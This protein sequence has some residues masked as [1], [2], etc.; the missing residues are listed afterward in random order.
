M[1]ILIKCALGLLSGLY[2]ILKLFPQ[3]DKVV[4]LS[5]QANEPSLDI[6][7]LEEKIRETHPEYGTVVLCRKLEGGIGKK[8]G[9]IFHMFRQMW[10]LATARAAVLDS[11][12][13]AASCLTH[14]KSLLVVQMWHS[15]G[16]MKKFGYS[17]LD[18]PEG[19][20]SRIARLMHMHRGYDFVLAAGE[21]YKDHLAEGFDIDREKI[22]TYPLPRLECLQSEDYIAGTRERIFAAYPRLSEKKNIVYVPT[23]RKGEG[24]DEAFAAAVEDMTSALDLD[25]YNLIIKAH[26]LAGFHTDDPRVLCDHAFSSMEMLCAADIVVTDY[27]CIL[28]EAAV[29]KKPMYF[30]AY[31]LDHYLSTRDIYI[32][33]RSVMP[34][35]ICE[36]AEELAKAVDGS[37]DF[38]HEK[39]AAFLH[40][41]VETTGHETKD[42]ADFLFREI[43]KRR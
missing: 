29:L 40:T 12:C 7:M 38:D 22:V 17:I 42:I 11:Y 18:Q 33:Y 43:E 4:F 23:F 10:H 28:Y 3:R 8:I 6:R 9:Y 25:R 32:D 35:P 15:V 21:G 39:L 30:Y 2:A 1:D 20:S 26:P 27:S 41:Y 19:S 37:A 24:E 14:K 5:R 16:T 13:I 34:G 36:S 31:D